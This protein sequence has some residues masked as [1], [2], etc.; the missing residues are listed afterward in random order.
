MRRTVVMHFLPLFPPGFSA[1]AT[2]ILAFLKGGY[3]VTFVPVHV[4]SR[5]GGKSKISLWKDGGQF[6]MLI[7]RMVMLVNSQRIFTP[8]QRFP[9]PARP[10]VLGTWYPERRPA[11]FPIRQYSSLLPL[12]RP[13]CWDF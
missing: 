9:D 3:N 5:R 10:G 11:G 8:G 13:G 6:V 4:N 12:S 1:S 2:G 7:L